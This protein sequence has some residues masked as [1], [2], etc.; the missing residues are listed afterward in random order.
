MRS[1]MNHRD[2][3][4]RAELAAQ[5]LA[6]L[7]PDAPHPGQRA[8]VLDAVADMKVSQTLSRANT[9]YTHCSRSAT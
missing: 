3:D 7:Y 8:A 6:A 4:R 1:T 5:L 2:H 9:R